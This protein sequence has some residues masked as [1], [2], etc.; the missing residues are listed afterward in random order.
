MPCELL[1][2]RATPV[3]VVTAAVN[4]VTL[5]ETSQLLRPV[6]VYDTF[7]SFPLCCWT[8]SGSL[9]IIQ[10]RFIPYTVRM[11]TSAG[12]T[13]HTQLEVSESL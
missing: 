8:A 12:T 7:G 10:W 11:D 6:Y 5:W 4:T 9:D 13:A 3:R 2:A 1:S